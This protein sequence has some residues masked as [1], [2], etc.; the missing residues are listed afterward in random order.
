MWRLVNVLL[1]ISVLLLQACGGVSKDN[2][3]DNGDDGN[4]G[5]PPPDVGPFPPLSRIVEVQDGFLEGARIEGTDILQFLAI[6]YAAPPLGDL[7]WRAPEPV[8][9]WRDIRDATQPSLPCIQGNTLDVLTQQSE[10]CLYL[11]VA[12]PE[13]ETDFH[14]PVMV[15]FHD[16]S[17]DNGGANFPPTNIAELAEAT[18]HVVVSVDARLGFLGFLALPELRVENANNSTGNYRHLD[19]VQALQWIQDNIRAFN[20]NPN[21][22]TLFG[23]YGGANSVCR[24]LS[25]PIS[26]GL[27]QRA[28]LQSGRCG[29]FVTD[30]MANRIQ[31]GEDFRAIW[32]C[33]S[34]QA[35]LDC[36]RQQDALDLRQALKNAGKADDLFRGGFLDPDQQQWLPVAAI[37]DYAFIATPYEALLESPANIEVMLGVT[38]NQFTLF[39]QNEANPLPTTLGS[40]QDLMKQT[41][42]VATG[43]VVTDA[44]VVN[45][46]ALY[47]V[48][49]YASYS[50]A[51]ADLLGDAIFSCPAIATADVLA[52]GGHAVRFYQ[53][54]RE[55]D[56]EPFLD[57]LQPISPNAPAMG[58]V[59]RAELFYLWNDT[60]RQEGSAPLLTVEA[61]WQ[62]WGSFAATGVPSAE[63]REAWPLYTPATGDY[64]NIGVLIEVGTG[65]K[66]AKCDY[67]NNSLGL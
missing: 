46:T 27:F 23:N 12:A 22:V 35:P 36:M 55:I 7:R 33:A 48:D 14:R 43:K 32:G 1:L 20:G 19:E 5:N 50:D 30:T 52:N 56:N 11:N 44:D 51:Y 62:Y 59:H 2:D 28:I 18:G 60:N 37:D 65:Y 49:A 58:T 26:A 16:E 45:L 39:L 4:G 67:L 64:L 29:P 40:Y 24:H 63:D 47:P 6:P 54:N 57:L 17:D 21:N 8:I 53:F 31:Q 25:S 41:L 9:P 34:N 61:L 42:P 13:A 38:R 3:D 66:A 15:W 10:D